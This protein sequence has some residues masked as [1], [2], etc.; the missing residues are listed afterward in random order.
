MGL[1]GFGKKDVIDFTER[2]ERDQTRSSGTSFRE[3]TPVASQN[4]T[5]TPVT[6]FGFF[7]GP[8][9]SSNETTIIPNENAAPSDDISRSTLTG[10]E[11]RR[12]LAK[13]LADMTK[14]IEDLSNETY[15]LRQRI[16]VLEKKNSVGF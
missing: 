1:F 7:G 12:R 16:E 3:S 2:Y 15:H 5:P 13:R 9:N 14:Q 6:S 10:E 11:R 8:S 4:K